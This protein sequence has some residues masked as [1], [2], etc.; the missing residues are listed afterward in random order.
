MEYKQVA[1]MNPWTDGG[2][3]DCPFCCVG[4][5]HLQGIIFNSYNDVEIECDLE[6]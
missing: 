3:Q 5:E 1:E 6:D 2:N 4:C